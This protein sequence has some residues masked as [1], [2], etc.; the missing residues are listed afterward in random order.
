M[1]SAGRDGFSS[2]GSSSKSAPKVERRAA[3][4][5]VRLV[6]PSFANSSWVLGLDMEVQILYSV[7]IQVTL[8]RVREGRVQEYDF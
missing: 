1:Y 7:F 2:G 6:M 5:G 8:G 4:A 3:A